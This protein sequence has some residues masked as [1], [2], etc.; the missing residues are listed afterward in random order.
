MMGLGRR[1]ALFPDLFFCSKTSSSP[2][3]QDFSLDLRGGLGRFSLSFLLRFLTR[4]LALKESSPTSSLVSRSLAVFSSSGSDC[5]FGGFCNL[6]SCGAAF[7]LFG[8]SSSLFELTSPP[9]LAALLRPAP[10]SLS[11]AAILPG[12][13]L[14]EITLP[15]L[16]LGLL[17]DTDLF[18]LPGCGLAGGLT[19]CCF[20]GNASSV[21][22]TLDSDLVLEVF[23]T[24]F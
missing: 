6:G 11:S 1:F 5:N 23:A 16:I 4:S 9:V 21:F 13:L 22:E 15:A 14:M 8:A 7:R 10:T 17:T 3:S 2:S 19:S 12:F 18:G 20:G 24:G